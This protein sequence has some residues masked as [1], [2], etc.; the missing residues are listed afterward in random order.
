MPVERRSLRAPVIRVKQN[1]PALEHV[2]RLSARRIEYV[3]ELTREIK[4]IRARIKV[5]D[6][7]SGPVHGKVVALFAAAQSD[8]GA[9]LIGD[10]R[11]YTPYAQRT[12]RRI[13]LH[14]FAVNVD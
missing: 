10:V 1:V 4:A 13:T 9:L 14:D 2:R 7:V 12:A 11:V 5:P 8:I 6:A 3:G